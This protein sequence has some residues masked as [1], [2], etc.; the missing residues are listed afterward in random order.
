VLNNNKS[1]DEVAN[2]TYRN[3]SG[4]TQINPL[5]ESCS[6][7][8]EFEFTRLDLLQPNRA[9]YPIGTPAHWSIPVCRG[10]IHNCISCGGSSY[11]YK[12]YLGRKKP[13]F[14]SPEKIVD[15]IRKLNTQGINVIFLF[16]DPRMG[17]DEN[18][19]H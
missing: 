13:A 18:V 11:S 1:L 8:D 17:V 3:I 5:M 6:D 15:D 10:C 12:K 2:L 9:V 16:Q 14:R 19:I 4:E 7:L